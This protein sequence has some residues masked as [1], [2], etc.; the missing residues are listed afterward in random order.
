MS[1]ELNRDTFA[2]LQSAGVRFYG[3]G[4]EEA[5]WSLY[6]PFAH[7]TDL[8][9]RPHEWAGDTVLSVDVGSETVF[10][11]S[12]KGDWATDSL[13]EKLRANI[14]RREERSE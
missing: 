14:S 9:T 7:I 3:Y 5:P 6:I 12:C 13:I 11:V 4:Y 10:S 2:E 1:Y 8:V